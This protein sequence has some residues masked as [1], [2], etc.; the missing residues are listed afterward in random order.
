MKKYIVAGVILLSMFSCVCR[1][2]IICPP[3]SDN[4]ME[5]PQASNADSEMF[6]K[7]EGK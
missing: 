5:M 3:P 1:K 7:N 2:P 6:R 4:E